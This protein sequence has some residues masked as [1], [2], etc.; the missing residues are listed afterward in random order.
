MGET[1]VSTIGFE[2]KGYVYV[3]LPDEI[4]C[5]VT[6]GGDS[7]TFDGDTEVTMGLCPDT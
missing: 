5:P 2:L 4:A 3:P 7:V 6:F 1:D